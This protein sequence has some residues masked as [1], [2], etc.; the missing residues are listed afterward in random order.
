MI[1]GDLYLRLDMGLKN[2][3]S[4]LRVCEINYT[5][6]QCEATELILE[7][8]QRNSTKAEWFNAD[9]FPNRRTSSRHV[10]TA[11]ESLRLHLYAYFLFK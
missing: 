4:M 9:R 10:N 11:C 5:G 3:G 7:E 1:R 2:G 8:E 6:E